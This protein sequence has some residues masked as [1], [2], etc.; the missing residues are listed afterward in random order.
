MSRGCIGDTQTFVE[1]TSTALADLVQ[2]SD[3]GGQ[4]QMVQR[5]WIVMS[6]WAGQSR[7]TRTAVDGCEILERAQEKHED[8]AHAEDL[9]TASGHVQ[10]ECLHRQGFG[11]GDGK[12]PSPLVLQRLIR[13]RDG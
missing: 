11:R 13:L 1:P 8:D 5:L 7:V 4:A 10:H 6:V 2:P 9:D 3:P 12:V